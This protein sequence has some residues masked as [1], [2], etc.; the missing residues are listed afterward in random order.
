MIRLPYAA[1]P[2]YPVRVTAGD[3]DPGLLAAVRAMGMP[4]LEEPVGLETAVGA[5]S[6]LI[7]KRKGRKLG[8]TSNLYNGWA[9]GY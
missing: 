3:F 6:G 9:V 5:W 8:A 7:I 2:S 1:D 4:I